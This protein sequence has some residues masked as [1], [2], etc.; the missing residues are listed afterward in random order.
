LIPVIGRIRLPPLKG[1][2]IPLG[3]KGQ[4]QILA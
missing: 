4:W 1:G 3:Y 2:E